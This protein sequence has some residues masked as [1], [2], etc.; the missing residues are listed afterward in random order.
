M[1]WRAIRWAWLQPT[2]SSTDKLVLVNL[3]DRASA[4]GYGYPGIATIA[5][6]T[7]LAE[8]SVR[9]SLKKLA[10]AGLL[11]IGKKG[12]R[13][14]N[15]YQLHLDRGVQPPSKA[16]TESGLNQPIP[17]T[18]SGLNRTQSPAAPDTESA[19]PLLNPQPNRS[20]SP[21]TSVEAGKQAKAKPATEGQ[22]AYIASITTK[23]AMADPKPE[24]FARASE[25]LDALTPMLDPDAPAMD[26]DGWRAMPD[27]FLRHAR[28]KADWW[29]LADYQRDG[30]WAEIAGELAKHDTLEPLRVING[31]KAGTATDWA[32]E[33]GTPTRVGLSKPDEFGRSIV[34]DEPDAWRELSPKDR[35]R[36]RKEWRLRLGICNR[37]GDQ[38]ATDGHRT[39]GQCRTRASAAGARRRAHGVY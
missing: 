6:D 15:D 20:E 27:L 4:E 12:R 14:A 24:T 38:E 19:E 32:A 13:N 31:G 5:G 35:A 21:H 36:F 29:K 3:G 23:L 10:A 11:T 22:R 7:E 37:C 25:L 16:D 39:C 28:L 2:G 1:S 18:E 33:H 17:D 34:L 8:R 30:R 26:R 9:R